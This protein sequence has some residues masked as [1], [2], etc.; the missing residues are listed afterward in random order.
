MDSS[1][2]GNE[3]KVYH[4]DFLVFYQFYYYEEFKHILFS[5]LPC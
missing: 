3:K 2:R 1:F 5:L 4:L